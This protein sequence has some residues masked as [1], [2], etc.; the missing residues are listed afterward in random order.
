MRTAPYTLGIDVGD[1]TV[2]AAV[3]RLDDGGR[4]EPLPLAGDGLARP[5]V[6]RVA[7][8]GRPLPLP[9][10]VPPGAGDALLGSALDRVGSPVPLRAGP[11]ALRPAD[12]VA[13]L[14]AGARQVAEERH[15]AP[16]SATVLTVPATWGE[17]RRDE[18]I[19]ALQAAGLAPVALVAGPVAVVASSLADAGTPVAPGSTVAVYDLGA[20][21]LDTAV[22]TVAPDGAAELA[23]V[24]PPPLPWGGRDLD[25]AVVTLIGHCLRAEEVPDGDGPAPAAVRAAAVA[26][27]EELSSATDTRVVLSAA[28]RPVALRLVRTDL[29]ELVA[30]DV[31]A[32]VATLSR[33]VAEAGW[34]V[35]DLAA[36]VLA[37][38]SA[39]MPLVAAT[40]SAGL[41]RPVV[42]DPQPG[43]SAA[44]GA[45]LL[46]AELL[47]AGPPE[48][49]EP[50]AAP[51]GPPAPLPHRVTPR[52]R[53]TPRRAGHRTAARALVVLA[54]L[55]VVTS[56]GT[57][58]V[59]AWRTT[60][61]PT[62]AASGGTDDDVAGSGAPGGGFTPAAPELADP[63]GAPGAAP[64]PA[65]TAPGSL[66]GTAAG[67]TLPGTTPPGTTPAGTTGSTPPSLAGEPGTTSSPGPG[68]TG[69]PPPG[70][71]PSSEP[72]PPDTEPLPPGNQPPPGTQPPGT[73]PPPPGTEPPLPPPSTAPPPPSTTPPPPSTEPPPPSTE[74]PAGGGSTTQPTPGGGSAPDPAPSP[75][76]DGAADGAA[77]GR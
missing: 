13:A 24:P 45:A 30:E 53:T 66:R 40:V 8:D 71:P 22:V 36:V 3:W 49:D 18:L 46:A 59:S 50:A 9:G 39:Q 52:R 6:V 73:Q 61:V 35:P 72:L 7:P 21:T 29:E 62:A 20:S 54:L 63:G 10:P 25:D 65:R 47:T 56:G 17:H 19:A 43:L 37:G 70:G 51:V 69:A 2:V 33:T 42:S 68:D 4:P 77:D 75:P 76:A 1:R 44:R 34:S 58:V 32:S 31:E 38:G 12:L 26:A 16:P 5:A 28:G 64:L 55:L 74:P 41:D 11:H 60:E 14:A 27:K 15:G 67:P 23:A 57:L 48:V